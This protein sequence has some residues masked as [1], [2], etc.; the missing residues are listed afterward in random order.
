MA[1]I[2]YFDCRLLGMFFEHVLLEILGI[3]FQEFFSKQ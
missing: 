3:A 2:F 1:I